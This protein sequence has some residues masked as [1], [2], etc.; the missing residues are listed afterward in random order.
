MCRSVQGAQADRPGLGAV[1]AATHVPKKSNT[2]AA[3]SV[4]SSRLHVLLCWVQVFVDTTGWA[5]TY[6]LARLAGCQVVAY[7]HYPMVSANM[8]QRVML[9]TSAYNNQLAVAKSGIK[10]LIKVVYYYVV[11]AVYGAA[12]GFANVS[13]TT[14]F[15]HAP[16]CCFQC[17]AAARARCL[18][19]TLLQSAYC[20][21][22]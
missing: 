15:L 2:A 22:V 7:T 1:S 12:G 9:R 19:C 21:A 3:F 4:Y 17:A 20:M 13:W 16:T 6:P 14:I 18:L 5:F 10:S 8:L 11:A